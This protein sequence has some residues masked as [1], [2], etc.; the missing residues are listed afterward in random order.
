[1]NVLCKQPFILYWFCVKILLSWHQ[2]PSWQWSYDCWIYNYLCNHCLSPLML[3]VW[4]SIRA[5]CTT[6]CDK[7]CRWLATGRWFSLGPS[8]SSTN[9]ADCHEITEILLKVALSNIKPTNQPISWHLVLWSLKLS[10]MMT[11]TWNTA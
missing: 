11:S 6:L 8:V 1:M 10:G 2:G 5:R 7:V 4:I 9:K 3:W